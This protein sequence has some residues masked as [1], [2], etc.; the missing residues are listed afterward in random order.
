MKRIVQIAEK[1]TEDLRAAQREEHE[2]SMRRRIIPKCLIVEDDPADAELSSIAL[3]STGAAVQIA[4]SGEKAIDILNESG[5]DFDIV[6]LD[7]RLSGSSVQGFHVLR[8][9]RSEF[10]KLH[11]VIVSGFIDEGLMEYIA[12]S[13]GGGYIGLVPKPLHKVDVKDI[14]DKHR[15]SG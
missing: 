15:L 4:S 7:L 9:I 13:K 5:S 12:R 8:H 11:V 2:T 3:K 10:P 14:M 6:F 1:L